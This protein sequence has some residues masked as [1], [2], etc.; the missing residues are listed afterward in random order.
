M[1][2]LEIIIA[3]V[4][5]LAILAL[6]F[7]FHDIDEFLF[8]HFVYGYE[9][10]GDVTQPI[11][12]LVGAIVGTIS[13]I[14]G[15]INGQTPYEIHHDSIWKM[16]VIWLPVIPILFISVSV[17]F[18]C[19]KERTV[20]RVIIRSLYLIVVCILSF[21]GGVLASVI[22]LLCVALFIVGFVLSHGG[23]GRSS[24]SSSRSSDTEGEYSMQ[25]TE[26]GLKN[27]YN[28]GN[29]LYRDDNGHRYVG[30]DG[31]TR[32]RWD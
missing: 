31:A 4:I 17:Y 18:V 29:G 30:R 14:Y 6:T 13:V 9:S 23:S 2:T 7:K 8:S 11:C 19:M 5:G 25:N 32:M 16:V 20:E 27:L 22:A 12:S 21:I 24:S 3:I 28:E 26:D 15:L 1:G 10:I